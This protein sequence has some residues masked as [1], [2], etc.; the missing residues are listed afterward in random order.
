MDIDGSKYWNTSGSICSK[1]I[2]CLHQ[3]VQNIL[4]FQKVICTGFSRSVGC[5]FQGTYLINALMLHTFCFRTKHSEL[6][7]PLHQLPTNA[8]LKILVISVEFSNNALTYHLVII[9]LFSNRAQCVIGSL[10]Q[11]CRGP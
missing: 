5:A 3:L 8:V 2:Y 4:E 1:Q 9:A 11:G 6:A 10:W 7:T